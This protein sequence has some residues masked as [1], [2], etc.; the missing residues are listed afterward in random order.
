MLGRLA[1][2]IVK[3]TGKVSVDGGHW[4][5]GKV[6]EM[7]FR[8][9]STTIFVLVSFLLVTSIF[10]A[11]GRGRRI[12]SR[13]DFKKSYRRFT[14]TNNPIKKKLQQGKAVY[15]GFVTIPSPSVV[16]HYA[17]AGGVDFI[18]IEAE[19]TVMDAKDVQNMV[20]AAENEHHPITP[21]VRIPKNDVDVAKR[22]LG[23]G[24]HGV[25]LPS[26]KTVSD[27]RRAV[28]LAKYAPLGNRPAG[29]ERA[30]GFL[31]TFKDYIARANDDVL[32]VV[33]IETKEAAEN[34]RKIVDVEGVDV[35]H[36]GP[37]DMSLSYAESMNKAPDSSE[38]KK[39]VEKALSRI[40]QLCKEKG[41]P[42]GSYAPTKTVA[43]EKM[44]RGYLFFTIPDD[45]AMIR[46][47]VKTFF[48][49]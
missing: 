40:E 9:A 20:R 34:F 17:L 38:V 13:V 41:V 21:I 5:N 32:V 24:V 12:R 44:K 28:R 8:M 6:F 19:H 36:I 47:G 45:G 3:V 46:N 33:M 29:L 26:I 14:K 31:A 42:M 37:Y 23:T 43:E 4:F 7:K 35:F 22:F 11:R 48:G 18:W 49:K 2:V 30:N 27:A 10:A 39:A 15:G 1:A 25:I 16:E